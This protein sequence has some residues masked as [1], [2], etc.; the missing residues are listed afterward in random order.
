[1]PDSPPSASF[2]LPLIE[3]LSAAVFWGTIGCHELGRRLAQH[4]HT[5]DPAGASSGI[6]TVETAAFGLMGLITAFTFAAAAQRFEARRQ[7]VLE[8]ANTI[9]TAWAR[10]DVLPPDRQPGL[11]QKFRG[12]LDSR[13]RTYQRLDDFTATRAE[14]AVSASTWSAIWEEGVAAARSEGSPAATMLLLPALNQMSDVATARTLALMTHHP[15]VIVGLLAGLSLLSGL[16][17]GYASVPGGSRNWLHIAGLA[18]I[19]SMSF[20]VILDLD[21]PRAGLIRLEFGDHLLVDLRRSMN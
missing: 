20:Y 15:P 12:Y 4:R 14:M 5:K 3:M 21:Y 2:L 7:L 6:R 17:A 9:S 13:L 8:E 18:L 1:M 19:L 11:R 16:L 10:L